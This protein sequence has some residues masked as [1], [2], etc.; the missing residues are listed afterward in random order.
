[1]PHAEVPLTLGPIMEPS[2]HI[3]PQGNTVLR[4]QK[5]A[6]LGTIS[7]RLLPKI[8]LHMLRPPSKAGPMGAPLT[9]FCHN[10]R[11]ATAATA[12]CKEILTLTLTLT[13]TL[14]T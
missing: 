10:R 5:L 8:P 2:S 4:R 9:L 12:K 14:S 11:S 6:D 3:C 7:G 13:L 1:M